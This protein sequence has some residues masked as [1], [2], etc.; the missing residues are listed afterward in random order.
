M[1]RRSSFVWSYFTIKDN[2]NA[3][4][5]ICSKIYLYKSSVTNLKKHLSSCH[6]IFLKQGQ[7]TIEVSKYLINKTFFYFISNLLN[8]FKSNCTF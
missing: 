7:S 5:D 1:N 3:K 2:Y 6:M 8:Y 4:C